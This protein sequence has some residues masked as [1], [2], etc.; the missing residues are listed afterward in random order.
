MNMGSNILRPDPH[1]NWVT[2]HSR[3]QEGSGTFMMARM[4]IG[5]SEA[6]GGSSL[7]RSAG[8][9]AHAPEA[10]FSVDRALLTDTLQLPHY[11]IRGHSIDTE[12]LFFP[13]FGTFCVGGAGG[14]R[15]P[16]THGRVLG[17]SFLGFHP[18]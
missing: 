15:A 2:G 12:H 13:F 8:A 16:G 4:S 17:P 6:P 1:R 5:R 3:I 7:L 9:V 10:K 14:A 18:I 11:A